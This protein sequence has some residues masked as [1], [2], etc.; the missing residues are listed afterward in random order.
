[1]LDYDRESMT[2][3]YGTGLDWSGIGYRMPAL[4]PS[5]AKKIFKVK[6]KT[7]PGAS[8]KT[9]SELQVFKAELLRREQSFAGAWRTCLDPSWQ[10]KL[11]IHEL[12]EA[13]RKMGY[14][15]RL[16]DV[17]NDLDVDGNG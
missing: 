12:C 9:R 3:P 13:C 10:G 14:R 7:M 17:W 11:A 8:K 4:S 2:S 16:R 6:E 1:M 5:P 15:G